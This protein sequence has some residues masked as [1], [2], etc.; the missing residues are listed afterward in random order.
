MCL[1]IPTCVSLIKITADTIVPVVFAF[2]TKCGVN[3]TDIDTV[4]TIILH[5]GTVVMINV[6]L[7]QACPN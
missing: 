1:H 4:D 5:T 2:S 6:G 7:A 3:Y